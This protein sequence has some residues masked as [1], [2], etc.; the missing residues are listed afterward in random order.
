MTRLLFDQVEM[1]WLQA[2]H[3]G[4]SKAWK[5]I[6]KQG[7]SFYWSWPSSDLPCQSYYLAKLK[8]LVHTAGWV[9]HAQ[10]L[11]ILVSYMTSTLQKL[12]W[13]ILY[14]KISV[15]V[16]CWL[17]AKRRLGIRWTCQTFFCKKQTAAFTDYICT[18]GSTILKEGLA[19]YPSTTNSVECRMFDQC[20]QVCIKWHSTYATDT[21]RTLARQT[22]NKHMTVNGIGGVKPSC[23]MSILECPQTH[24]S[25]H[26]NYLHWQPSWLI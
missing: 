25:A 2:H 10:S 7:H 1:I 19:C 5:S 18:T 21:W 4:L 24:F 17:Y 15:I 23:S 6:I 8:S 22:L 20:R 16:V 12:H 14:D 9:G 11:W 26:C 13:S 3:N